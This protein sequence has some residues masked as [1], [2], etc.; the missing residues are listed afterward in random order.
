MTRIGVFAC[1]AALTALDAGA[2]QAPS[3]KQAAS[4]I[5]RRY[6][7]LAGL[8]LDFEQ[9]FSFG[10]RPPR[11][12][13]GT[14]YLLRPMRMRWEYTEPAGKL[15]VGDGEVLHMYSPRANQVRMIRLK[16]TGDL[17]APLTFLLGR[18][19]FGKLFRNLRLETRTEPGSGAAPVLVADGRSGK[20]AYSHVEFRY[21]PEDYR[22]ENI[23]VF[24]QD[25][26]TT[27]FRFTEE[28]LNPRLEPG[29]F[30]FE[31]PA[32][33]DVIDGSGPGGGGDG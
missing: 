2:Q 23:R 26:A 10:G 20:A 16:D 29:L 4:R 17:R 30:V 7:G 24:G 9:T 27:N 19:D 11:R 18:L 5:E 31:A 1:L 33:A 6:N 22:L 14:L 12:E 15:L 32:G 8:T 28:K 13:S 25:G 3:W 21:N